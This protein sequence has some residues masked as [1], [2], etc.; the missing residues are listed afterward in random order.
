MRLTANIKIEDKELKRL[1]IYDSEDGVYLFGYNTEI[2]SD[3]LWDYWFENIEDA[4][5]D[6]IED[7][8]ISKEDWT[9]IPDPL[10]YCQHD[11]INPVRI[12]GRNLGK[13]EYG[14]LEKL[15]DGKWIKLEKNIE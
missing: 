12:I 9:E 5:N 6:C 2:D 3:S 7:Y 8:N 13:P 11:W 1:M 10:E 4:I 15:I 14:K